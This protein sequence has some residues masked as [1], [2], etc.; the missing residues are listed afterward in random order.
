MS[1]GSKPMRAAISSLVGFVPSR[2]S[3]RRRSPVSGLRHQSSPTVSIRWRRSCAERI[4]A[5]R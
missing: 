2:K 1:S 4:Q 3:A 5:R